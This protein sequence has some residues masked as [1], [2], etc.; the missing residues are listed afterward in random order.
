M[1]D[2]SISGPVVSVEWLHKHLNNER[3]L[4]FDASMHKVTEKK[5]DSEGYQIPSTQYFDIKHVFSDIN[6][7]FPNTVPSE[8][9]FTKEAK[10]LGVNS[11]SIIVV[12]DDK[13]IYSSARARYLF[14]AFGFE[15]VAVLDGGLPAWKAKG[16]EMELKKENPRPKGNF[17]AN[18]NPEAF[19][20]FEDIKES[21]QK[22]NHL[23]I[24][25]RSEN[26]FK[27]IV[28]EPRQGLRSGTIPNSVNIPFSKLLDGHCFKSKEA[29]QKEFDAVH[30]ENE[31]LVFSCGS[32]ITACVLALGAE[33]IGKQDISVYDGSWTEYGSLTK[34]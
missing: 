21:S 24:D 32:G 28:P 27:G 20:F 3:L 15:M 17:Q 30:T 2:F 8:A 4:I 33:L 5:S 10:K 6:A 31:H 25:A 7:A 29:I 23:I 13:G 22:K 16:Y 18:Y 11:D 12:Y 9:Q 26:R 1:T 14:K 34:K 19:K